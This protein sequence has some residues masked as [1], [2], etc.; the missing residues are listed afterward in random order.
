MSQQHTFQAKERL[1][2]EEREFAIEQKKKKSWKET[3][4]FYYNLIG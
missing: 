1:K 2:F 4:T 3:N